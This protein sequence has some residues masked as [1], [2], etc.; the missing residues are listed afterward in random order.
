MNKIATSKFQTI[1]WCGDNKRQIPFT[2]IDTIIFIGNYNLSSKDIITLSK[3]DIG[4]IFTNTTLKS[5]AL[6]YSNNSKNAQLKYK[7]F[8]ASLHPLKIAKN[9]L[10]VK[11]E[12]HLQ[13]I[14]KHNITLATDAIKQIEKANSLEELLGIEGSFSRLYFEAYFKLYPK[15]LAPNKRTKQP[16]KDPVN[17]ILS[18]NYTLI[19]NLI[20]IRLLGFGFEPTIGFLHKPF[21]THNALSSDILELFRADINQ[22]T[23]TLFNEQKLT[24]NDFSKKGEAVY[25][26]YS[27]RKAFW[28]EFSQFNNTLSSK[29]DQAISE[30]RSQL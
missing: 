6:L 27:S 2:L 14:K 20:T 1:S 5:Y 21:R 29:I 15:K 16:P 3:A 28:S 4:V 12:S 18:F 10:K 30:I 25:L 19:Y 7:Q 22:F 26:K 8:R 9:I 17:A 24:S 13:Q 11:I 23:F